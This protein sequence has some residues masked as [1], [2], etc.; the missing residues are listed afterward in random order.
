ME[1]IIGKYT[2]GLPGPLL[3]CIGGMHGNERAGIRAIDLILKM[4]EVEPILI[5][6]LGGILLV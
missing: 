2:Q 1:R 4:L 3:V 5:L 6:F